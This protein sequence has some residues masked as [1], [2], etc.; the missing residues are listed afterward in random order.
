M[1]NARQRYLG[2]IVT[3]IVGVGLLALLVAWYDNRDQTLAREDGTQGNRGDIRVTRTEFR[4]SL[5]ARIFTGNKS[6][7]TEETTFVV[8]DQ[9]LSSAARSARNSL[10]ARLG[11]NTTSVIVTSIESRD[12]PNSCLGLERPDQ[13]CAQVI[14]PGFQVTMGA[15]GNI[16]IYRTN[17]DG[18]VV[19]AVN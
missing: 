6:T 12:W 8:Q 1:V 11:I 9:E 7:V 3:L 13:F 5:P 19:A 2:L 14:V 18:S 4:D 10:T 17:I 16:Y 15:L